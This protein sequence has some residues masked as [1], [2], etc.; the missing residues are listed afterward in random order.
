MIP[1]IALL[2]FNTSVVHIASSTGRS[3]DFMLK[4]HIFLL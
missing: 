1:Q 2:Y 3:H 4:A